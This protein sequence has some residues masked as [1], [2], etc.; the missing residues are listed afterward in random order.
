MTDDVFKSPF[1]GEDDDGGTRN[2]GGLPEH[3]MDDDD[4]VGGGV[5]T[6]G[7]TAVDRGTGEMDGTAQ[8][9]GDDDGDAGDDM[10]GVNNVVIGGAPAGG[11]QPYVPA[12]VQDDD[13]EGGSLPDA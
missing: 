11:A 8:T 3:E 10:D 13:D 4:T 1:G 5:M 6:S 2:R 12:F 9:R 7:A